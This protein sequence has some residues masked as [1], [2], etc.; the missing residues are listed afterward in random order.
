LNLSGTGS[1]EKIGG[2]GSHFI[3]GSTSGAATAA[4]TGTVNQS[5]GTFTTTGSGEIRL[6]EGAG[7]QGTWNLSGG[8]ASTDGVIVGWTTG[9]SGTLRVSST[10][11]LNAGLVA[12]GQGG[13]GV[14]EQTGGTI[15]V[16]G[17]FD[18]QASADNAG[19]YR[20][21]SGRLSVDGIISTDNGTFAWTAGTITRAGNLLPITFSDN[22]K[23]GAGAA[24]LGLDGGKTFEVRGTFDKTAGITLELTGRTIPAY[25]GSGIDTG[26]FTLGTTF[27]IVGTFDPVVD[28]ILGLGNPSNAT[29]I[30]ETQGEG[31]LFNPNS[32]SVFWVQESG[33]QVTLNYSLVPEPGTVGLLACA[34]MILGLRRRRK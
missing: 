13:V 32:Q 21:S 31:R 25:D 23:T 10:A 7:S 2:N 33:G 14:V 11:V 8:V 1:L 3:I 24:T 18:I 30:S 6:G 26:S 12:I 4:S 19:S 20:L 27:G 22:L 16:A 29:F 9:G 5:G 34:G 17:N 15:N 28:R